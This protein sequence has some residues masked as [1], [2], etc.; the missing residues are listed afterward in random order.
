VLTP[1]SAKVAPPGYYML[2][3]L[4]GSRVPSTAKIVQLL[5]K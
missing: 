4:N 1:K 2:F 5:V 3:A